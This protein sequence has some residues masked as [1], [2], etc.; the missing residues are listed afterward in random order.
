MP[1]DN[2]GA[3]LMLD[4]AGYLREMRALLAR[5][6]NWCQGRSRIERETGVAFCLSGAMRQV[7]MSEQLAGV[8]WSEV[9]RIAHSV[10][11]RLH[12]IV[13]AGASFVDFNDADGRQHSDIL[14]LLDR[15]IAETT[16]GTVAD[17]ARE[18]EI[19]R[20]EEGV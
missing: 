7:T 11:N 6:E 12:R 1:F 17:N 13:G 16:V 19:A 20:V 3:P 14:A 9:E 15:A 2:G 5:P 8:S 4:E 10:V 18:V